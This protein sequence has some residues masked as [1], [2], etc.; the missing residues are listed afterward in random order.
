MIIIISRKKSDYK[1]ES[2][3]GDGDVFVHSIETLH[4]KKVGGG[5]R[6]IWV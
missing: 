3:V 5:V 4:E 6:R 2:C 1:W